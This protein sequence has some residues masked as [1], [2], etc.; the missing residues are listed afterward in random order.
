MSP[1]GGPPWSR[2]YQSSIYRFSFL[3]CYVPTRVPLSGTAPAG[4]RTFFCVTTRLYG[5]TW[6]GKLDGTKALKWPGNDPNQFQQSEWAD[7]TPLGL[8]CLFAKNKP[9]VL[10]EWVE[11]IGAGGFELC[12]AWSDVS[13]W[14]R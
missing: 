8:H 9:R 12:G 1:F 11:R 6:E 14:V 5:V 13:N 10:D 4:K 3:F 7:E 2:L